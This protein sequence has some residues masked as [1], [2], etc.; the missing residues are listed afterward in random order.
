MSMFFKALVSAFLIFLVAGI[1]S[2]QA[3]PLGFLEGHLKIIFHMAVG[4]SSDEMPRAEGA[5]ESY[6]QYP[7]VILSQGEKKEI[8]RITADKSGNYRVALPPGNYVLDVQDRVAKHVHAA[9]R[10]FMVVSNQT[11]RVDMTIVSGLGGIGR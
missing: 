7:L 5:P 3:A 10:P 6:A 9:P 1:A 2:I 11:V 8:A 4:E